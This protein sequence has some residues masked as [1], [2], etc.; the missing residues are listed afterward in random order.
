[1]ALSNLNTFYN[2]YRLP[3]TIKTTI[4]TD[5][6]RDYSTITAWEADLDNDAIYIA[7]DDA[8]GECYNDS[9]FNES[10][11]LDGGSSVGL[12]SVLLTSADTEKHDGTEN[13]GVRLDGLSS[14]CISLYFPSNIRGEVSW[15]D[16]YSPNGSN[17]TCV[18]LPGNLNTDL[19]LSNCIVRDVVNQ[20]SYQ[21]ITGIVTGHNNNKNTVSNNI[22]YNINHGNST[23][24][25]AY[26]INGGSDLGANCYNN[27]I[28]NVTIDSTISTA[29]VVGINHTRAISAEYKNNIVVDVT[30]A[31]SGTAK[32]FDLN[33]ANISEYNL[34]SDATASGT[35]SLTNK[36]S[37]NQFV[38]TVSGSE[39]LHLKEGADA[40]GAGTDLGTTPT[41]VNIDINGSDRNAFTATTWDI[42][43]HQYEL[44]ASIGTAAGRDYNTITAW[45]ADLDNSN[46]Y[47]GG[48]RAR[49]ECYN[50]S[51]FDES[52]TIDGGGI[53][54]LDGVTL[55]VAEGERHDGT[56]GSG[57]RII[58]TSSTL[59][60]SPSSSPPFK[61]EDLE[62]NNNGS[63]KKCV[64]LTQSSHVS[65]KRVAKRLL[66]HN[67][68]NTL[69]DNVY[70]VYI[71]RGAS[72]LNSIIYNITNATTIT[73]KYSVGIY[74]AIVPYAS[75]YINN[76]TIY[77]IIRDSNGNGYGIYIGSSTNFKVNNN[78]SVD[79]VGTTT[80]SKLAY[81]YTT[82]TSSNNLSSD[83][84]ADDAGGTGH[85]I[86]KS[87]ANQ[88]VSI[89]SGS[90]D[91]HLKAGADAID[92]GVDLGTTPT[93]V[94]IDIN[95]YDRD[96]N[97]VVWDIGAH[98]YVSTTTPITVDRIFNVDY[99]N[100]VSSNKDINLEW[101]A[102]LNK[103]NIFNV[104]WSI[105]LQAIT[106]EFNLEY[107][108]DVVAEEKVNVGW[109][110]LH[111]L[112]RLFNIEYMGDLAVNRAMPVEYTSNILGTRAF[113]IGHLLGVSGAN[114]FDIEWLLNIAVNKEINISSLGDLSLQRA[115]P[116]DYLGALTSLDEFTVEYMG[117]L[118][119]NQIFDVEWKGS[120]STISTNRP[121]N[122]DWATQ[123]SADQELPI[124]WAAQISLVRPLTITFLSAIQTLKEF[125]ADWMG[126][127]VVNPILNLSYR[128]NISEL[129]TYNIDY[130][131][132]LIDNYTQVIE[133]L[134]SVSANKIVN[135]EWKG[136]ALF[137]V[138]RIFN[139]EN[140][141]EFSKD[142]V[143]NLDWPSYVGSSK[144][145]SIGHN[146]DVLRADNTVPIESLGGLGAQ[147]PL[148]LSYMGALSKMC[149]ITIEYL[150]QLLKNHS[151][152]VSWLESIST[153][154]QEL[155][156]W[157]S[158]F[159][160]NK[161]M[162]VE[163]GGIDL[164]ASAYWVLDAKNRLWTLNSNTRTWVLVQ[165]DKTRTWVL[166][167]RD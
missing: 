45:E 36:L 108:Q 26:G 161:I 62:L 46:I 40:I 140:R 90:E 106:K 41:G 8:V 84:T 153:S 85:L 66:I 88:F 17:P 146:L 1:M 132:S 5:P 118:G 137:T 133:Y 15:I 30:N 58:N 68:Y 135:I 19:H 142:N 163:W 73:D 11:V 61:I 139:I 37:S 129:K 18:R 34:S 80:G 24:G 56:A 125:G 54:G 4:G 91:L 122:I 126:E 25:S 119:A 70:A 99:L 59:I 164:E 159:A 121:F 82:A 98:E 109:R 104:D 55:T 7:G 64:S 120:T 95:G 110:G 94:N 167:K 83:D 31:G 138:D 75:V 20:E 111:S 89:V 116:L 114:I 123:I 78:I 117:S 69:N 97:G 156:S 81:K 43:A 127:L 158:T 102:Q 144:I 150:T 63:G 130:S 50:D 149:I 76:N 39:D 35:G 143:Y 115:I 9:I 49:G 166:D 165:D 162:P 141:T 65:M 148:N 13:T 3:T 147:K 51:V 47:G 28:Y 12:S 107:L 103:L 105:D 145:Y 57:A 79:I 155:V 157:L 23:T 151:L 67:V 52:V 29:N 10:P 21:S 100:D 53:V 112:G 101:R 86:N 93:G 124:G 38:S 22:I 136:A 14:I 128:G 71:T 113:N 16:I 44:T 96:A 48:A 154:K 160:A 2:S 152:A 32:C 27:T 92:A 42:G 33:A 131:G 77:N 74:S 60:S 72:I 87:S 6:S 134:Q